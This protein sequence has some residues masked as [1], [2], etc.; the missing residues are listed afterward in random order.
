M[1]GYS[2]GTFAKTTL[3]R[4]LPFVSSRLFGIRNKNRIKTQ[5]S[6][7]QYHISSDDH[8]VSVFSGQEFGQHVCW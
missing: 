7:E 3:L 2:Q 6:I 4:N 1:D 5:I 8:A